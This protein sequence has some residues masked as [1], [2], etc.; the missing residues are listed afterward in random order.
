VSKLKPQALKLAILL[1]FSAPLE[2]RPGQKTLV[3]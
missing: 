2:V 3:S 1:L